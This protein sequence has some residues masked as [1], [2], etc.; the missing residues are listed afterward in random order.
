MWTRMSVAH[1]VKLPRHVQ[2]LVASFMCLDAMELLKKDPCVIPI[3]KET[4]PHSVLPEITG[5]SSQRK[6]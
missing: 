5:L 6:S 1:Q 4:L 2:F 3:K